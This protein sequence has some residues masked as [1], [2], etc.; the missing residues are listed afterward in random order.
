MLST[1]VINWDIIFWELIA[2][3]LIG[4][5]LFIISTVMYRKFIREFNANNWQYVVARKSSLKFI[6]KLLKENDSVM[7]MLAVANFEL[8]NDKEFIS[9][10]EKMSGNKLL[11]RKIYQK[12]N[13]QIVQ[14]DINSSSIIG[15]INELSALTDED[16]IKRLKICT[17][18]YKIK[19]EKY[20]CSP[21]ELEML[22]E[23]KSDRIKKAFS[24]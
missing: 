12:F 19:F 3:L 24:L 6:A 18:L 1:V 5:L 15:L 17:L 21:E 9:Y 10:I 22:R 20:M 14:N 16:S 8:Y 23:I 4:V 13:F 2:C 11:G 7:Y